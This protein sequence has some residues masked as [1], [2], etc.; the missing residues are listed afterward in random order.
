MAREMVK[1]TDL[2]KNWGFENWK[3]MGIVKL[4]KKG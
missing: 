1:V 3:V 2:M 4:I